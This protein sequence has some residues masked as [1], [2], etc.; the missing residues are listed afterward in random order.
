[1]SSTSSASTGPSPRPSDSGSGSHSE[2]TVSEATYLN[3]EGENVSDDELEAQAPGAW[4]SVKAGVPT[5]APK[6]PTGLYP[7]ELADKP[8]KRKLKL[9]KATAI[10]APTIDADDDGFIF[11][12][13]LSDVPIKRGVKVKFPKKHPSLALFRLADGTVHAMANACSHQGVGLAC[14]SVT[15]VEDVTYVKC[16]GHNVKFDITTGKAKRA[17]YR[18]KMYRTRIKRDELWIRMVAPGK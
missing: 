7:K 4:K 6:T 16:P 14:G 2:Y 8:V 15:D 5:A 1:M 9:K 12:C 13:K 17:K 18:Q 3:S 11:V 10:H